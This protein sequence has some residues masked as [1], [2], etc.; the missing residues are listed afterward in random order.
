M[1]G[2]ASRKS[3]PQ[4]EDPEDLIE[5]FAGGILWTDSRS[6]LTVVK[7]VDLTLS[8]PGIV[9]A[10]HDPHRDSGGVERFPF[11]LP[12][13]VGENARPSRSEVRSG[14]RAEEAAND[15]QGGD[16]RRT[17]VGPSSVKQGS[18][19]AQLGTWW[20]R[21]GF[22][23]RGRSGPSSSPTLAK[24]I[25]LSARHAVKRAANGGPGEVSDGYPLKTQRK[26]A[27]RLIHKHLSISSLKSCST[28]EG[29]LF[30]KG[31][32]VSEPSQP[33]WAPNREG[34]IQT[35][36]GTCRPT[37]RRCRNGDRV[38]LGPFILL[39][40]KSR[41]ASVGLL[42]SGRCIARIRVGNKTRC[43]VHGA[44]FSTCAPDHARATKRSPEPRSS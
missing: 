44:F 9:S 17:R 19:N 42:G 43:E 20:R 31:A 34:A 5:I 6:R 27:L 14:A 39:S 21:H 36:A 41:T 35:M 1:A 29:S 23:G 15:G 11:L 37:S 32:A 33:L 24:E 4:R 28:R 12:E 7:G 13:R 3:R 22:V 40:R 16:D 18:T 38:E 10:R 26:I 25:P 30:R 2:S 8:R